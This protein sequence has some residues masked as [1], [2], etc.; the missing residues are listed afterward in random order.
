MDRAYTLDFMTHLDP[1]DELSSRF[2]PTT[3]EREE[4]QFEVFYK[5]MLM[6]GYISLESDQASSVFSIAAQ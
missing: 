3:E 2:R 4:D 6:F 1:T 5:A